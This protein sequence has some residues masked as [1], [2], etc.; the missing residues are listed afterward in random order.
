MRV[1]VV[2]EGQETLD[3]VGRGILAQGQKVVGATTLLRRRHERR[4]HTRV[5]LVWADERI[6]STR[7]S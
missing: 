2:D 3:Y 5:T 1:G 7:I 4:R 6:C